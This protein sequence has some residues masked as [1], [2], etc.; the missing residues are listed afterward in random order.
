MNE[1][2]KLTEAILNLNTQNGAADIFSRLNP[3]DFPD[4]EQ[5][6][7]CAVNQTIE[8]GNAR[9][10]REKN[11]LSIINDLIRSGMW[12][13]DFDEKGNM[14]RVSWSPTF[15]EMLGFQDEK[16]FPNTLSAW[17]DRLHPE[18]KEATLCAYWKAIAGNQPYDVQYRLMTKNGTYLWFR[19]AG[20]VSRRDD[21]SPRFFLGTFIDITQKKEHEHLI[22]EKIEAQR[23]LARS[24]KALEKQAVEA[25]HEIED[26][27]EGARTGLWTIEMEEGRPYRMYADKTMRLLLGVENNISPEQCF[28]Q[29][30]SRIEPDYI[31][32][33]KEGIQEILET[34][35][36]EVVYPWNH[37]TLGQLYIRCGGVPDRKSGTDMVRLRGYHQDITET[38]ETKK[39]QEKALIAALEEAKRA[40]MAKT[41]FLSHMSHDI[42]TPINGI[43]GM[44]T[45]CEKNENDWERQKDCLK[46]IRTSAE[47]LLSL[48]NDVLDI[49]KLESGAAVLTEE[50]FSLTEVL[51][52]CLS[53]IRVQAQ[54]SG[55]TLTQTQTLS[56]DRLL[57]SPLSLRQILLNIMSNAVKY[58]RP[59]G[60]IT[61]AAEEI[62]PEL[63]KRSSDELP[64][65]SAHKAC[66]RF[67]IADTGIGIGSEFLEHLF[68]PFTQENNHAR[69]HYHGT[70]LG[71]AITKNLTAQMGG[72]ISV[73]SKPGE[74][75]VFTVVIPFSIDETAEEAQMIAA[76][77]GTSAV[78]SQEAHP[79]SGMKILLAE[80]NEIN[81][82]IACYLLEEAGANV[83]TAENGRETL[84]LFRDSPYGEFD[85][86][87]MDIMMPVMDGL[88]ATRKIR[89]LNRKDAC[90]IPIIAMSAN[91][92][93]EDAR[94]GKEAGMN[95]YLAKPLDYDQVIQV[96]A[97]YRRKKD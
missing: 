59:D 37:P 36:A 93:S 40:N 10:Q 35:R 14:I 90:S 46:K 91:A 7:V 85:C 6:L 2:S 84:K 55:L 74:G 87:L 16:D 96:V 94:K 28:E 44:L 18:D 80:D 34:G 51:D 67:V 70:G 53:I 62:E 38:I 23:E 1:F 30:F 72:K 75:S 86:I 60:N 78:S 57:G 9:I 66:L 63:W 24:R 39:K 82:E 33:V 43:L 50:P 56:H 81:Q 73:T 77:S 49:S 31:D 88:T 13:M 15:R 47:H 69:T 45:I 5:P 3:E 12:S 52:N 65:F 4:S 29:W 26:I 11:N 25:Q 27:L 92:F 61:I 58:N 22:L 83:I 21:G 42:R 8:L 20:E 64:E 79:L 19:A 54:E 89:T 97:G 32:M 17:S 71:M 48:I 68:E 41:E 95:E 76:L